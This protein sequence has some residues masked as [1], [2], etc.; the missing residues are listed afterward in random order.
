MRVWAHDRFS[1]PL[2]EGHRFPITK[3]VRLREEVERLGLA[4]VSESPPASWDDLALVHD[5]AYLDRVRAGSLSV[6][7]VRGLGLPWSPQLVE[8]GRRSSQGT[9]EAARDALR[10]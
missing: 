5:G 6:R 9:V 1:I 3:Y 7:E 10:D 8:R 4:T 2:P